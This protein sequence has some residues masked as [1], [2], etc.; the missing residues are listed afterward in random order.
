MDWCRLLKF[1]HGSLLPPGYLTMCDNVHCEAEVPAPG[2]LTNRRNNVILRSCCADEGTGSVASRVRELEG[3]SRAW[4]A[5]G[6][7]RSL[8]AS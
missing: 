4:L 1:G 3:N 5:E 8:E 6:L 2:M 7:L